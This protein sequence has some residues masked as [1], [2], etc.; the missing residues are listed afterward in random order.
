[1]LHEQRNPRQRGPEL[2]RS[3]MERV[4]AYGARVI[5]QLQSELLDKDDRDR[6]S[7]QKTLDFLICKL[8]AFDAGDPRDVIFGVHSLARRIDSTPLPSPNYK[9]SV[10]DVFASFVEYSFRATW[11]LDVICRHW[12]PVHTH[13]LVNLQ[14]A[15]ATGCQDIFTELDTTAGPSTIWATKS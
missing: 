13:L 9:A 8:T 6:P 1:M 11:Q 15:R 14:R 4:E 3:N 2:H 10:L 5:H 12:A 7:R